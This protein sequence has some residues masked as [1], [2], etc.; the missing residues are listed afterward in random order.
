MLNPWLAVTFQAMRL[1]FEAQNA[2][3]LRLMRLVGDASNTEARAII[4]EKAAAPPNAQKAATKVA[5]D[6]R[7]RREAVTRRHKKR[8][9]ANRRR[10]SHNNNHSFRKS[11]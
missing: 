9:G 1:G 10:H 2:M 8:P 4:A 6:S 7:G 11:A 5:S 3:A